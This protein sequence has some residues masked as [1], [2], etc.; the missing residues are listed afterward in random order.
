MKTII[1]A[2]L[3]TSKSAA[4]KPLKQSSTDFTPR[5][6]ENKY[7]MK[8]GKLTVTVALEF[9]G[10]TRT[11]AIISREGIYHSGGTLETLTQAAVVA[12]DSWEAT[13]SPMHSSYK[14]NMA[15][16]FFNNSTQTKEESINQTTKKR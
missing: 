10:E 11:V 4:K 1:D 8:T 9:T 16:R 15:K 2:I 7:P 3:M 6:Y 12:I 5:S 13:C 14:E